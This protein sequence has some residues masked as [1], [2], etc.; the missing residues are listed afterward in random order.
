MR[1]FGPGLPPGCSHAQHLLQLHAPRQIVRNPAP[2][3]NF[4]VCCF[5]SVVPWLAFAREFACR[6]LRRACTGTW[7]HLCLGA[8]N[9]QTSNG[10][11]LAHERAV[12]YAL[13]YRLPLRHAGENPLRSALLSHLRVLGP[14]TPRIDRFCA[15]NRKLTMSCD[16]LRSR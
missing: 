12:V 3:A 8:R 15:N 6:C 14:F 11:G 1:K 5:I 2:A 7:P 9:T 16:D 10:C 13:P 4:N